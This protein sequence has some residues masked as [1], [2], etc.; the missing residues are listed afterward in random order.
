[1]YDAIIIGGGPAGLSAAQLLGRARRRVLLCD[2]G[3]P[4][5][6]SSH[7]MHGFLSRDGFDPAEFRR[8]GSSELERYEVIEVRDKA[9][10]QVGGS[11]EHFRVR[12][13]GGENFE[14]RRLLLAF[15]MKDQL[16]EIEGVRDLWGRGVFPCPYCDGWEVKDEPLAAL[17][18]G[19]KA[20][21]FALLL[22][23]WSRSLILCTNGP[24]ELD[25]QARA[26]LAKLGIE[27]RETA[28][29]RVE[30]GNGWLKLHFSDG[31]T[32]DRR[33]LFFHAPRTQSSDLAQQLGC[34]V[35]EEGAVA[36]NAMGQTTVPGVYAVGDL[37]HPA[38]LPFPPTFVIVAAAQG[39]I[40]AGAIDRDLLTSDLGLPQPAQ[41]APS[42]KAA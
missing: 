16:P 14:A 33:A 6:A 37:A 34:E 15:G 30:G 24:A 26:L 18:N 38:G 32:L 4:R 9:V 40:A 17:G 27:V 20:L 42:P 5:N 10:T 8:I 11:I 3:K 21:T 29:K 13:D 25:S 12:L 19:P 1:M 7:T 28:L 36:V 22:S 23:K 41:A 2:T 35:S 39:A 31:T